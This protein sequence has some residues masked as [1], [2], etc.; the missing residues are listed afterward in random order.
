MSAI[1][2]MM[3]RSG[4]STDWKS[5]FIGVVDGSIAGDI[6]LPDDVTTIKQ[7]CFAGCVDLTSVNAPN[8]TVLGVNAFNGARALKYL[9]IGTL[10]SIG[11]S[12]FSNCRA[13]ESPIVIGNSVT[14]IGST[15]FFNCYK[16][17]YVDVGTGVTSIGT[18]AFRY[19]TEMQY[20]IMRPT[21]PPTLYGNNFIEVSTASY[22][23]YVPDES[24]AAYKAANNW[25]ALASRIFPLSDLVGGGS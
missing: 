9:T 2:R 25:S 8:V 6:T 4:D 23:I 7:Y 15:T 13:L 21:S 12:V 24:V 1:R 16:L 14:E 20:V 17:P 22:P 19:N 18:Q 5:L 3:M 11:G 10:Q